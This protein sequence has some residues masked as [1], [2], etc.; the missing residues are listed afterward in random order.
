MKIRFEL[1]LGAVLFLA[2]F[3]AL[4]LVA[5]VIN[6]PD[7]KVLVAVR[8]MDS[9]EVL[10]KDSVMLEEVSIPDPSLVITEKDLPVFEG[11]TAV[12][13]IHRGELLH[14][15]SFVVQDNPA[16][17]MHTSLGLE[18]P[19]LAAFVIPVNMTS[20]PPG[21][22]RG[23]LVDVVLGIG[24]TA[25]EMGRAL[26]EPDDDKHSGGNTAEPERSIEE[27][28]IAPEEAEN[29]VGEESEYSAYKVEIIPGPTSDDSFRMEEAERE[30]DD[31]EVLLPISKVMVQCAQVLEV[32]F[33]EAPGSAYS[34]AGEVDPV[35]GDMVALVLEVPV[36]AQE[37]LTFAIANGDIRIG[38][39]S[40]LAE[41]TRRP[42]MGMCWNDLASFFQLDRKAGLELWQEGENLVGP[43]ASLL[44]S[45]LDAALQE[46]QE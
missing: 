2:A 38:L 24:G 13:D 28:G 23:D 44:E 12:E 26:I 14:Q 40:P 7:V 19:G 10:M 9:G 6:P 8:D 3:T 32:V 35:E 46:V 31:E 27:G 5:N 33:D 22:R 45:R 34:A 15:A 4:Y 17:E 41:E 18:D 11:A 20:A 16:A 37:L 1:I 43:G 29:I 39:R 36:E 42:T 21:I 25:R 30:E